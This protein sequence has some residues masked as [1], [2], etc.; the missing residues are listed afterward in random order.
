[1]NAKPQL[2]IFAD[3]VKCSHGA[4]TGQL[5]DESLF[6]LRARGIGEEAARALLNHA[7]AADVIEGAEGGA[8]GVVI[9]DDA[10]VVAPSP[11]A[12]VA[13]VVIEY[14]V[15]GVNPV[16]ETAFAISAAVTVNLIGVPP[17]AGVAM[18]SYSVIVDPPLLVAA[19]IFIVA[20]VAV[21]ADAVTVAGAPGTVA[22]VTAA[23][24]T[25]AADPPLML[26]ATTL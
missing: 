18:I 9:V 24:A 12:L 2:E 13:R 15:P 19:P 26:F 25:E 5:D 3:D 8:A 16:S 10:A 14:V 7:F 4:T 21:A 1:M 20:V 6:Y 17:P 23:E 11:T 22:G